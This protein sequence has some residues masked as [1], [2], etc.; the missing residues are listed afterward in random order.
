MSWRI[1][2]GRTA[3]GTRTAERQLNETPKGEAAMMP[4]HALVWI[5][6]PTDA[7]LLEHARRFFKA[8]DRMLP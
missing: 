4:Y 6:H 3:I 7:Q 1:L 5:D 2:S 8:A